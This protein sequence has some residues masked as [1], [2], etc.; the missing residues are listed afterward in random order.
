MSEIVARRQKAF[1]NLVIAAKV[2]S[3]IVAVILIYFIA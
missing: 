3:A 2:V 1:K